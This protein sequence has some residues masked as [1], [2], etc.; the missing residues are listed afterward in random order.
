VRVQLTNG[1]RDSVSGID[2]IMLILPILGVATIG[3]IVLLFALMGTQPKMVTKRDQLG[4]EVADEEAP[5]TATGT[6]P[7]D[8]LR[9]PQPRPNRQGAAK[10]GRVRNKRERAQGH[11]PDQRTAPIQAPMGSH[12]GPLIIPDRPGAHGQ[13]SFQQVDLERTAEHFDI[14]PRQTPRR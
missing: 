5:P 11:V 4:I 3:I 7:V 13:R 9:G 8:K 2:P 14:T 1:G 10:P 6:I 12:D